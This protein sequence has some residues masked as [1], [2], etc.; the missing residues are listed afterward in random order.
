MAGVMSTMTRKKKMTMMPLT[1]SL[2]VAASM[3]VAAVGIAEGEQAEKMH[4]DE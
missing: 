4:D 2:S 1:T 3:H